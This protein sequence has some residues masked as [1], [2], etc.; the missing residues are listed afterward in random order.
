MRTQTAEE[1][2]AE[3]WAR[4]LERRRRIYEELWRADEERVRR[5]RERDPYNNRRRPGQDDRGNPFDI[6]AVKEVP[7]ASQV[8]GIRAGA[9]EDEIKAAYKRMAM[10]WHPDRPGGS[11]EKMKDINEAREILLQ[12]LTLSE[13]S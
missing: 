7:R 9:T 6:G 11:A 5:Q 13:T 10:A 2:E 3:D 12:G 1:A 4:T 8:L